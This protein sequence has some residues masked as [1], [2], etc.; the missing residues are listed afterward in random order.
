MAGMRV[1]ASPELRKDSKSSSSVP[2]LHLRVSLA[3][4]PWLM[5]P[6]PSGDAGLWVQQR[7]SYLPRLAIHEIRLG[8]KLI[9]TKRLSRTTGS[10][11][12]CYHGLGQGASETETGWRQEDTENCPILAEEI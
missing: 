6:F 9:Q 5:W 11:S 7:L 3:P 2:T 12:G 4:P 1:C 10:E 8:E